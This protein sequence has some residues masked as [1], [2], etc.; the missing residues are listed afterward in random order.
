MNAYATPAG[1]SRDYKPTSQGHQQA[2]SILQPKEVAIQ[3][4]LAMSEG[5][6]GKP[7][8]VVVS[9]KDSESASASAATQTSTK[10]A[11]P[12]TEPKKRGAKRK[13]KGTPQRPLSAYNYFVREERQ[14]I[15]SEKERAEKAGEKTSQR[16]AGKNNKEFSAVGKMVAERWRELSTEDRE[17]YQKLAEQDMN[18]YLREMNDYQLKVAKT[19]QQDDASALSKI[20]EPSGPLPGIPS[21]SMAGQLQGL[22][23]G[24][25]NFPVQAGGFPGMGLP[26]SQL[27]VGQRQP[28][29]EAMLQAGNNWR[30]R[31]INSL[32]QPLSES[33][34]PSLAVSM[35]S[36]R[37][38]L[39]PTT[40]SPSSSLGSAHLPFQG[41]PLQGPASGDALGRLGL[42]L[43]GPTHSALNDDLMNLILARRQ[44]EMQQ[45]LLLQQQP[46]GSFLH[47]QLLREQLRHLQDT[48]EAN[49]QLMLQL[50]RQNQG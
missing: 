22:P 39:A 16:P 9:E 4:I 25:L 40:L 47:S 28:G 26:A 43:Q 2:L 21:P 36:S 38:S 41:L 10:E 5:Q 31:D 44:Q 7:A 45:Q 14:R 42:S 30:P 32:L 50:Q 8:A 19:R 34:V 37:A 23:P 6:D 35:T 18:R 33:A 11:K 48:D 13:A 46:Q 3:S 20:H 1:T 27:G 17:K 29:L 15:A 49:V 24:A 12:A